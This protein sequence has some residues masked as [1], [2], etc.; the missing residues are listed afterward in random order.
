VETPEYEN[1]SSTVNTADSRVAAQLIR[2]FHDI[3]QGSWRWTEGKFSVLLKPP[4]GSTG[5]GRI[6]LRCVVAEPLIAKVGAVT[7][8]A[9][10]NG[11]VLGTV[12][13]RNAGEYTFTAPVPAPQL[14]A[15]AITVDFDLDKFLPA[16]QA[17][18]RELG[19]IVSSVAVQSG[20]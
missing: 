13:W 11:G 12:T 17:D 20:P 5:G 15:G 2:G 10:L 3:E 19:L 1:L 4:P 16:G 7:L 6:V 14:D 8:S 18:A 9:R